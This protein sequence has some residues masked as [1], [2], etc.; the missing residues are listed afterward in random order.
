L[1][2]NERIND[3]RPD[4]IHLTSDDL[5]I[6]PPGQ[7]LVLIWRNTLSRSFASD[8]KNSGPRTLPTSASEHWLSSQITKRCLHAGTPCRS[9]LFTRGDPAAPGSA[10]LRYVARIPAD[11]SSYWQEH[12]AAATSKLTQDPEALE[13]EINPF[14]GQLKRHVEYNL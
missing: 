10:Y 1:E 2:T 7:R 11:L 13:R 4:L 9:P 8:G 5:R 3:V 14:A 6:I 12:L